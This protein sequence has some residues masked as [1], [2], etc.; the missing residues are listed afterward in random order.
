MIKELYIK[1]KQEINYMAWIKFIGQAEATEKLKKLYDHL[2]VRGD[3]VKVC[4]E[5]FWN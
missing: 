3:N 5:G 4:L 1:L 2:T